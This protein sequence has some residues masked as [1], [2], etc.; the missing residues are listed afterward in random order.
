MLDY[1]TAVN[2]ITIIT[3]IV[4]ILIVSE[5]KILKKSVKVGFY[6]VFL[7][8]ALTS[9]LEW[10]NVHLYMNLIKYQYILPITK[11]LEILVSPLVFLVFAYV[12]DSIRYKKAVVIYLV[13]SETLLLVLGITGNTFHFDQN[14]NYVRGD[15]FGVYMLILLINALIL[16]YCIYDLTNSYKSS[17]ISLFF[18]VFVLISGMF[19]QFYRI[20]IRIA[21]I[22]LATSIVMLYCYYSELINQVDPLTKILNRRCYEN[23]LINLKNG[24]G[25]LLFDVNK[26]KVINDTY[27]H[28]FGDIVLIEVAQALI[29]IYG[30]HGNCYRVGG[31]EFCVVLSKKSNEIE[32]H[33]ALLL[34]EL[35]TRRN[36]DGRLPTISI[37]HA[38]HN[39]KNIVQ[40]TL[41]KADVSMYEFKRRNASKTKGI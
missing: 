20:E 25:V 11:Q 14:F 32:L 2:T 27:G 35:A 8:L 13:L 7:L 5:N 1:H 24:T 17:K 6:C 18:I 26:F 36:E 23:K 15:F 9:T 19:I 21:W 33:N 28:T 31:D 34:E 40:V 41:E 4:M 37:G 16:F 38:I 29:K 12:L 22:N 10:L 3:M 30:K 39:S